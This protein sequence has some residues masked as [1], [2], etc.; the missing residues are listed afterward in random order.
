[1]NTGSGPSED[2][3]VIPYGRR[4]L[5][6]W[7]LVMPFLAALFGVPTGLLVAAGSPGALGWIWISFS[8]AMVVAIVLVALSR[9]RRRHVVMA[10]D[11]VGFRWITDTGV[12]L[13]RW[14]S[15]EGVGIYEFGSV[16][17]LEH[18]PREELDRDHPLL[19]T[20]V[21]DSQP[22]REGLPRLR[23]R[24]NLE[25][26][27]EPC[28]QA[29]QRWAPHLW[30]GRVSQRPGTQGTSDHAGHSERLRT[31]TTSGD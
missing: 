16:V 15:L 3:S 4:R 1:M 20:F 26:N 24:I 9:W 14:D 10:F 25:G 18:C 30:F 11:A 19:W 21:R 29:C 6:G 17:T 28:E 22:L 7:L 8:L 31:R 23:Y 5:R 27:L 13:M 2:V 12:A